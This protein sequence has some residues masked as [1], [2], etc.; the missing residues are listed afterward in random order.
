MR[1]QDLFKDYISKHLQIISHPSFF[2]E[3]RVDTEKVNMK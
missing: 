2:K 1:Q 3:S